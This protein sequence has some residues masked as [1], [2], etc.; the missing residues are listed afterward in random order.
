MA[1]RELVEASDH[2]VAIGES[3]LQDGSICETD[4]HEVNLTVRQQAQHPV[5]VSRFRWLR[6][7]RWM[8]G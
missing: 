3:Q 5:Q 6:W 8:N 2:M 4:S 7:I 1:C